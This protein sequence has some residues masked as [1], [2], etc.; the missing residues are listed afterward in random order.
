ME[1]ERADEAEY[2]IRGAAVTVVSVFAEGRTL[3]ELV[4]GYIEEEIA[5]GRRGLLICGGGDDVCTRRG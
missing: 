3:S 4:K 1:L 5:A 2:T